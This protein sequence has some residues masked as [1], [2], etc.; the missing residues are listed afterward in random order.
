MIQIHLKL[1]M[2]KKQ[3]KTC[4]QWL[5]HLAS[6]YNFAIR[7]IELNSRNNIYFRKLEFQ[8]ILAGH[9]D[10]LGI[11]SHTIQGV[12]RVAFGSWDRCFKKI[13]GRPR[14]KGMRNKMVS[15]PFPDPIKAPNGKRIYLPIL[16]S[17]RFHHQDIPGRIKSGRLVKRASG[18]YLCI[19]VDAEP[20][21]ILRKSSGVIGV[22]P[23]FD[24]VITTSD[25][26]NV[27]HPRE[28][29]ARS[30]RLAQ[31]QRS[32][33]K[34]LAAR[35]NERIANQRK[36]RNHKLSRKLVSENSF[37]AFSKDGISRIAKRFGKSVASSGHYQL[38]QMLAYKSPKSGT[39]YVEVDSR[40]S[41]S[42][43]NV[44]SA[45]TGPSGLAGLS[46]RHWVCSEC[47]TQH[48]RDIN[49]ARNTLKAAA[50]SAVERYAHA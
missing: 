10:K 39:Q 29:E 43:C 36:D 38:R 3:E 23:G 33:N 13:S 5:Y 27:H 15:I 37:I 49:A 48:D 42:T 44:C 4:E 12:L 17:I 8:N 50:G 46:V 41:T 40:Y 28:L 11:S 19:F 47:G 9:S 18:W 21:E 24:S 1:R 32:H 2:T 16:G 25:G 31:A 45:R 7:K 6:I 20:R 26:L 30:I 22:D 34:K 14:L 35:I